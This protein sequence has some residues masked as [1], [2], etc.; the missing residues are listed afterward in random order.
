VRRRVNN[1]I[2]F[3]SVYGPQIGSHKHQNEWV[4]RRRRMLA[5]FGAGTT[6]VFVISSITEI[7][8]RFLISPLVEMTV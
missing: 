3:M 5:I 6:C 2:A 7:F 8:G 1:C 4:V